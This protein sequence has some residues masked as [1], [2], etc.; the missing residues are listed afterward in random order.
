M[1]CKKYMWK[2]YTDISCIFYWKLLKD[3][4]ISKLRKTFLINYFSEKKSH[5][6]HMLNFEI[7]FL[8]IAVFVSV[9]GHTC[10][11]CRVYLFDWIKLCFWSKSLECVNRILWDWNCPERYFHHLC[12]CLFHGVRLNLVWSKAP[13]LY[14]GTV[15]FSAAVLWSPSLV[16]R[17]RLNRCQAAGGCYSSCPRAGR[18]TQR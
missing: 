13:K 6:L 14:L 1:R 10:S 15:V 4:R 9:I 18:W 2:K 17:N 12:A 11:G 3:T 7:P 16:F 5:N 8:S